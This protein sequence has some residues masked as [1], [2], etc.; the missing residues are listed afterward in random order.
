MRSER[1][2]ASRS[3]EGG[4]EEEEGAAAIGTARTATTDRTAEL[5]AMYFMVHRRR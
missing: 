2:A 4:E 3:G 5:F 1:R